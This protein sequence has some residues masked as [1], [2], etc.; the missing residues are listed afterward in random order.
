MYMVS[1]S[2]SVLTKAE[3]LLLDNFY[4]IKHYFH[5][6]KISQIEIY[7]IHTFTVCANCETYNRLFSKT[8]FSTFL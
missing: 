4:V 3:A 1:N 2:L 5:Q 6:S 7:R 8:D